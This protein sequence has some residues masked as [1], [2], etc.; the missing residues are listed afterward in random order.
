MFKFRLSQDLEKLTQ[1]NWV[2]VG[3]A[4]LPQEI[5]SVIWLDEKG[6]RYE[7]EYDLWDVERNFKEKSWCLVD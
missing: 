3:I 2:Y 1:T 6:R 5:V 4:C 7:T